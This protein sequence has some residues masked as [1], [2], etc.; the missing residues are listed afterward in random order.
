MPALGSVSASGLG[1]GVGSGSGLGTR[2]TPVSVFGPGFTP[3]RLFGRLSE[4]F[5]GPFEVDAVLLG[6]RR[7]AEARVEEHARQLDARDAVTRAKRRDVEQRIAP[8]VVEVEHFGQSGAVVEV[9]AGVGPA[10]SRA[11][12]LDHPLRKAARAVTLTAQLLLGGARRHHEEEGEE[13]HRDEHVEAEGVDVG[14][15]FSGVELRGQEARAAE[16]QPERLPHLAVELVDVFEILFDVL[17]EGLLDVEGILSAA[18]AVHPLQPLAAVLAVGVGRY[19]ELAQPAQA[20]V[21]EPSAQSAA[22][23][24]QP[25]TQPFAQAPRPCSAGLG[26]GFGCGCRFGSSLLSG[27]SG[28]SGCFCF[29]CGPGFC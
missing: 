10:P 5:A 3:G 1:Y 20:A 13:D 28:F 7:D 9:D 6:E 17:P 4:R 11:E 19:G 16:E 24:L 18:V 27:C 25:L 26:C 23:A 8:K 22:P 15:D 2:F 29:G 14:V 21:F 12:R